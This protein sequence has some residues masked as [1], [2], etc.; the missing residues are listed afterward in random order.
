MFLFYADGRIIDW[1]SILSLSNIARKK[2]ISVSGRVNEYVISPVHRINNV[3]YNDKSSFVVTWILDNYDQ[4]RF[5]PH[6]NIKDLFSYLDIDSDNMYQNITVIPINREDKSNKFIVFKLHQPKMSWNKAS[7]ICKDIGGYL[8]YFT[9]RDDLDELLAFLK[10]SWSIPTIIYMHIGLKFELNKV[11]FYT[12][13][14]W[15][16]LSLIGSW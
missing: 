10:L 16:H 8:P 6:Q 5:Y 9:S 12:R 2:Y 1:I 15:F 13:L 3:H 14:Q 4:Y 7:Q 11:S